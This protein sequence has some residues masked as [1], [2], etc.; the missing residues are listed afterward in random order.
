M[1][2]PTK[3]AI[4]KA[5]ANATDMASV[6]FAASVAMSPTQFRKNA[7]HA[8]RSSIFDSFDASFAVNDWGRKA[9][10]AWTLAAWLED[11]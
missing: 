6:G 8:A 2:T 4:D 1:P 11:W 7:G 10:R 5:T 9:P 3:L